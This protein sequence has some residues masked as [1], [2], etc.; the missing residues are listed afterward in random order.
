[1]RWWTSDLHLGHQE[2]IRYTHRPFASTAEMDKA[3][4]EGWNAVVAAGDEV[5]VLGDF[6]VGDLAERLT[7]TTSLRGHKTLVAGNRDRCWAGKEKGVKRWT[8]AYRAAGFEQV[9]QGPVAVEVA[10]HQV[11]VGHFPYDG[12]PADVDRYFG[13]RPGDDGAWLL[14]GHVHDKWRQ[15]GRQVNVGVDAW[16]GQPV[17]EDQIAALIEAGKGQLAPLAWGTG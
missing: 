11:L 13:S 17:S 14:H 10:G 16:G 5:W 12:D 15:S 2:I 1:M 3:I 9:L 8:A 7:I 4:V 6:A